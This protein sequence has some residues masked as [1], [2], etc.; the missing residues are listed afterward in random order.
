MEK[1]FLFFF[2]SLSLLSVFIFFSIQM[3]VENGILKN[4][5]AQEKDPSWN[6]T[7]RFYHLLRWV[8]PI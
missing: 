1:V 7:S 3:L 2:I 8:Y 6:L 4:A 5:K